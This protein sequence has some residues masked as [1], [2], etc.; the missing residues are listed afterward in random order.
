MKP[1]HPKHPPGTPSHLEIQQETGQEMQQVLSFETVD[2]ML[3]YDRSETALPDGV[4]RKLKDS[5][6]DQ[7][8]KPLPQADAKPW[9]PRKD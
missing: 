2:E 3:S 5:L 7:P 9:K 8:I 4:V 1:K 6:P